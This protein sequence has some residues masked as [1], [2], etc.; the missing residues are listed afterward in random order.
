MLYIENHINSIGAV[1][2]RLDTNDFALVFGDY[3]QSGLAW[4]VQSNNIPSIDVNRSVISA[5][6]SSLLDG[7]SLHGLVQLNTIFNRNSRLLDFLLVNEVALPDCTICEAPEPLIGLDAD[8]PALETQINMSLPIQ[9]DNFDDPLAFDFNR[10]DFVSMSQAL[11]LIDW[12]YLET[13]LCVNEA[14]DYFTS[15]LNHIISANV[16]LRRPSAKPIWG[17]ARLRYL[18]RLRSKALRKYLENKNP[19]TKQSFVLASN[20]YRS[21]N[22]FLYNGYTNRMQ[23]KLRR[24]PKSFWSFVKTKKKEDGLPSEI[25]FG[26]KFA[27]SVVDKSNLLAERFSNVFTTRLPLDHK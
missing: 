7:F 12:Q 9:Y 15:N 11:A 2:S 4:N 20:E 3:N 8:H 5:S 25:Y 21:Y 6:C 22:R 1:L 13:C 23:D 24:N 16:P 27:A 14:V 17:N 19:L 26:D 10:A 18:K